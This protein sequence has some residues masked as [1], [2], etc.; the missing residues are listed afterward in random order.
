MH[1]QG[2]QMTLKPGETEGGPDNF[3]RGADQWLF[4]AAGA[5]EAVVNGGR[6]ELRAGTL[7]LF[8]RGD[9]HEIRNTGRGP[10]KTLNVHVP[11][12]FTAEGRNCRPGGPISVRTVMNV[13]T[14]SATISACGRYR[15]DLVRHFN[16]Q[17]GPL[18]C[19]VMLNPSTADAAADDPTVRP[20]AGF[21]RR[22]GCAGLVVVNLFALRATRPADLRSARDPVGAENRCY[23][24]AAVRR[25]EGGYVV[26]AWGDHGAWR[27][28]D[29]TVLEWL[30]EWGVEPRC[31]GLTRSGRPRHP[32]YVPYE[33]E[34]V[35]FAA[36][37]RG[38]GVRETRRRR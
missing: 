35:G 25:A 4:V 3:L 38:G 37:E 9:R 11:P 1:S 14:N 17:T 19:F 13:V 20:G 28:Q 27:G 29:A 34:L 12:A 18:A 8:R 2:A 15:Y 26:C 16:G 24:K 10:L 33:A 32:L 7:V 22:W 6:V 23:V 21:A 5:G 30:R 31:L 36:D